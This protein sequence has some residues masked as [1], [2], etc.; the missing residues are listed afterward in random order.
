MLTKIYTK[1][2]TD[3]SIWIINTP[4]E[5]A[6]ESL[7]YVQ[8]IGHFYCF[9]NFFT[10]HEN[11]ASF[12]VSLT[13]SGE[14]EYTYRNKS[15]ILKKGDLVFV[16]CKEYHTLRLKPNKKWD[17]IWVQFNGNNAYAYYNQYVKQKKP[18]IN[19]KES[20]L[21]FSILDEMV[22]LNRTKSTYC[23]LLNS[24][25]LTD[26]LTEIMILSGSVMDYNDNMPEYIKLAI[27]D[28]DAH[29]MDDL[30]LDHFAKETLTSKFHFLKEFKRYTGFT[31][32]NYLQMVRI[33][34]AKRLLKY[35]DI[36][37]CNIAEEC[38]FNNVPNF[39][40]T[41]KNK[42]GVTPLQFRNGNNS[43]IKKE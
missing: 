40:V 8:E 1:G 5:M 24:K 28:I 3:D 33:N 32:Y 17:M 30:S 9:P 11:I 35:S 20:N 26:I 19:V 25:Y 16:D 15:Y 12:F 21:I 43:D 39:F 10:L 6:M 36:S 18:I 34:N 23:E 29:F 42:T 22:E 41:F 14:C 7:F 4:S 2:W 37:V 31:P 38:G 27:N 13:I